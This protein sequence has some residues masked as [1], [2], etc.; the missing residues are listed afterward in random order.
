MA[1]MKVLVSGSY[2]PQEHVD[3][4]FPLGHTAE[5]KRIAR[6]LGSALAANGDTLVLQ[7]SANNIPSQLGFKDRIWMNPKGH[8]YWQTADFHVL[9]GYLRQ[10]RDHPDDAGRCKVLI[11]VAGRSDEFPDCLPFPKPAVIRKAANGVTEHRPAPGEVGPEPFDEADWVDLTPFVPDVVELVERRDPASNALRTKLLKDLV[12][13]VDAVVIIGGGKATEAVAIAALEAGKLIPLTVFSATPTLSKV[14]EAFERRIPSLAEELLSIVDSGES[15]E[16]IAKVLPYHLRTLAF[17]EQGL[18][19]ALSIDERR[20]LAKDPRRA[21]S[22]RPLLRRSS[23][24]SVLLVGT[25]WGS[26]RGGLSTV[27]R[28]LALAIADLGHDVRCLLPAFTAKDAQAAGAAGV[29]LLSAKL[30]ADE[31]KAKVLGAEHALPNAWMPDLIIGHG[32]VTGRE[33]RAL[34]LSFPHA[35][36]AQV[37]HVVPRDIEVL[38]ENRSDQATERAHERALIERD[39]AR[40]ADLVVAIGPRIHR[41]IIGEIQAR[42]TPV[43]RLDPGISNLPVASVP[44]GP[45]SVLL[46]GR[47]EDYRLKGLDVAA[48]AMGQVARRRADNLPFLEFVILGAPKGEGDELRNR[49]KRDARCDRLSVQVIP[50][51][52]DE[53]EIDRRFR[54]SSLILM[55]SRGE[56]FGLV[57]Q[58]ALMRGIPCLVTENSGFGELLREVV[59]EKWRQFVLPVAEDGKQDPKRWSEAIERVLHNRH[60]AFEQARALR[61]MLL[62]CNSWVR[63]ADLLIERASEILASRN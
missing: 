57:A 49:L 18:P 25:E 37:V 38:K 23:K 32:R 55:P 51:E 30:D 43:L 59:P 41:S 16:G 35:L 28:E 5:F 31:I 6:R 9:C 50:Y 63:Q 8:P 27:N 2:R 54:Q 53:D 48:S 44:L 15:A 22:L 1:S 39:L 12:D 46:A 40:S 17:C 19:T 45:C 61:G 52:V 56:G 33:A 62:K 47:A 29:T 26:G 3:Y 42:E 14:E 24:I 7:W 36:R 4:G 20:A 10:V 60:A 21:C 11:D 13:D 58:E 34:Q